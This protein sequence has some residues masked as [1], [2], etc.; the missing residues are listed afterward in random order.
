[1]SLCRDLFVVEPCHS[2]IVRREEAIFLIV[3]YWIDYGRP[4][5]LRWSLGNRW[6]SVSL[7]PASTVSLGYI[8]EQSIQEGLRDG[9]AH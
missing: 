9:P 8:T 6:P 5:C 1:M 2:P 3:G 4:V 7:G